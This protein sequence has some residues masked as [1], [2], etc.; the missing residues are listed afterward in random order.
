MV[1]T[2][3]CTPRTWV[4]CRRSPG[5][6]PSRPTGRDSSTSVRRGTFGSDTLHDTSRGPFGV[7]V[8]EKI[9]SEGSKELSSKVE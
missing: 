5:R 2:T 6:A 4:S 9:I 3:I 7:T 1:R 8:H